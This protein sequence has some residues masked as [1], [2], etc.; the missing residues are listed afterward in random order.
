VEGATRDACLNA[1]HRS[2]AGAHLVSESDATEAFDKTFGQKA[3]KE[4]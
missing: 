3:G 1:V 4:S 2:P